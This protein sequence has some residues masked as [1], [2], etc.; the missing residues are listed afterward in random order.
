MNR[1]KISI[2]DYFTCSCLN[3]RNEEIIDKLNFTEDEYNQSLNI[4]SEILK[5]YKIK[6]FL[7]YLT[8][9]SIINKKTIINDN[10][11]IYLGIF[12]KNYNKLL[13]K[14]KLID[15]NFRKGNIEEGYNIS[16]KLSR[17]LLNIYIS[18]YYIEEDHIWVLCKDYDNSKTF[19]K[20]ILK[21]FNLTKFKYNN[22]TY[23]I[24]ENPY[25][26]IFELNI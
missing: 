22:I 2:L 11:T 6:F 8:L 9:S 23:N 1:K 12:K 24:P 17:T 4:I 21:K 7:D 20:D 13:E 14:N 19:C 15:C 3:D 16:F 18:I 26:F 10:N 5:K 25:N